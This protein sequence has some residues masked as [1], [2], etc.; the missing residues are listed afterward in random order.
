MPAPHPISSLIHGAR[1]LVEQGSPLGQA[2]LTLAQG[3]LREQLLA[4][5]LDVRATAADLVPPMHETAL[6]DLIVRAD[7]RAWLDGQRA[8]IS[9][10]SR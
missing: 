10:E 8:K 9:G 5:D 1:K 7:L 4:H 3:H 2:V 6:H